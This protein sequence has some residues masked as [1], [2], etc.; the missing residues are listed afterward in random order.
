MTYPGAFVS[1]VTAPQ[2]VKCSHDK[3]VRRAW[4]RANR[5][6]PATTALCAGKLLLS[7]INIS[8]NHDYWYS[9][10]YSLLEMTNYPT[11]EVTVSKEKSNSQHP[12]TLYLCKNPCSLRNLRKFSQVGDDLALATIQPSTSWFLGSRGYIRGFSTTWVL[13]VLVLD[14]AMT[15]THWH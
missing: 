9:V 7:T 2:V 4:Y 14:A 6:L 8:Q 15:I 5:M 12:T 1:K 10:L 13:A 3:W 11:T